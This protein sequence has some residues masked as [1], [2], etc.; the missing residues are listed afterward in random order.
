MCG[1]TG[2]WDFKNKAD[3]SILQRMN[4]TLSHRGPDDKGIFIE[5][6]KL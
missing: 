5:K 3:K 4:N 1:I 2:Y 6:E